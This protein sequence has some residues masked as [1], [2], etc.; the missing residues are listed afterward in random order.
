[1]NQWLQLTMIYGQVLSHIV[2]EDQKINGQSSAE[3]FIKKCEEQDSFL[4]AELK[5]AVSF[6]S[7]SILFNIDQKATIISNDDFDK[8]GRKEE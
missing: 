1:M 8:L 3:I 7:K 5:K 4:G 6:P 2:I